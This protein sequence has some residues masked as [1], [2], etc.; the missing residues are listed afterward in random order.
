MTLH[1]RPFDY[2]NQDYEAAVAISRAVWPL[3]NDA[4]EDWKHFD[5]RRQA[6]RFFIR[7]VAEADGRMVALGD[8]GHSIWVYEPDKYGLGISVHPD[9]R[10]RGVGSAIYDYLLDLLRDRPV[11][12]LTGWTREDQA[13][14]IR[15]LE[16]RGFQQVMRY[17]MSQLDVA[18]FDATRFADKVH[19]V[20]ADPSIEITTLAQLLVD[21][22]ECRAKLYDADWEWLQ[23]IPL[24]S[25][26]T[27]LPRD[28]WEKQML[29]NPKVLAGAWFIAVEDGRYV[30][31]TMFRRVNEE[32]LYT[33]LTAVSRSHRRRGL[34][35]ALKVKAIAY[36]R[37]HGYKQITTDNEEKNPMFQLNLQLGFVPKPAGLDYVK[38]L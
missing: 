17:P 26:P 38:E 27:R 31:S 7:I 4:V 25:P 10:G 33:G 5:Q 24:P 30:G 15:F 2:S 32:V 28:V 12:Q 37:E 1:I 36:A 9:H 29:E 11:R 22:P 21:D 16:K 19:Q 14:G 20:E 6:D 3:H 23:D 18:T 13:A 34:A 35:T 8:V